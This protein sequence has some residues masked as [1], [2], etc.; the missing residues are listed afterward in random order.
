MACLPITHTQFSPLP[1]VSL[2]QR[3]QHGE[4]LVQVSG[5]GGDVLRAHLVQHLLADG[6]RRFANDQLALEALLQEE[7]VI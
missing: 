3:I 4:Q 6:I 1:L 2:A 7:G 5:K